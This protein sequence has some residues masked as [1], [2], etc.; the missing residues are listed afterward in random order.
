M[1]DAAHASEPTPP[2]TPARLHPGARRWAIVAGLVFVSGVVMVLLFL[3]TLATNNRMLYEANFAWLVAVNVAVAAFLL[4]IIAW[5]VVRLAA[6]WRRRKFGSQ[7]L[8]KLA[9]IFGLVGF[10]PGLL[11]YTVSY[12][13]VSRSIES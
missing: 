5:V 1:S 9:L 4:A 7:L 11:I 6:R 2:T 12:Q 13:F 8:V 10:L 3:L